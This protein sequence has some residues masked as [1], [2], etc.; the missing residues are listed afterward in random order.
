MKQ[1]AKLRE[2]AK[3]LINQGVHMLE[4]Q[5]LSLVSPIIC[6]DFARLCAECAYDAG[7]REVIMDWR[8]DGMTRLKYLRADEPVF[9]EVAPWVKPMYDNF[10]EKKVAK[11]VLLA[12]DPEA[13]LGVD[14]RRINRAQQARY[15]SI[16]AYSKAQTANDFQWC[17]AAVSVP[18]WA[19]KVFPSLDSEDAV[20]ALWDKIFASVRVTGDGTAPDKW[21]THIATQKVLIKKLN[22]YNFESL[23]YKNSLGTN[24]TVGLPE[25]HYWSGGAEMAK[26]GVE[27]IAN[28]PT[29]EIFTL[30]HRE[31]VNGRVYASMPLVLSG[32]I[33]DEFW[34]ELKNGKI[35]DCHA[36]TGEGYLRDAISVDSGAS[37]LGEVA[38]V[39]YDSPIRNTGI[40]FYETL[41]DENAACHL[42]FGEAY[43]CINGSEKMSPEELAAAGV[44]DSLTHVDFMVGTSDLSITGI[45]HDGEEVPVFVE[46]NFA[47]NL[48]GKA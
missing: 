37:Y 33:V 8:D 1:N 28:L 23:R 42:A 35:V 6:A 44:N 40:L 21:R 41:F 22:D 4:G 27:F 11:L 24:L 9:D 20:A 3:L 39:P 12:D 7:A 18:V 10:L 19:E 15:P 14:S 43:P 17:V 13:L 29:E 48:M 16:E 46:G 32:N 38:L 45:T 2:Y 26:L 47:P 36:Q 25:G 30:P 5:T 31:K 34:M